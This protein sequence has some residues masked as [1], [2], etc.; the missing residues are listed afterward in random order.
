M[1]LS[2]HPFRGIVDYQKYKNT[3]INKTLTVAS[4]E[5]SEHKT[6]DLL[7]PPQMVICNL[8]ISIMRQLLK[9]LSVK[10][11]VFDPKTNAESNIKP[12]SILKVMISD[13]C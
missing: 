4:A 7:E 8:V 6:D 3:T 2:A 1:S 13:S 5:M 10:L 11:Y 9:C 12:T